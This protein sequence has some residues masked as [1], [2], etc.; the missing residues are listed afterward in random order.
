MSHALAAYEMRR[1]V[2]GSVVLAVGLSL[3]ALVVVA[4]YPSIQE[5]SAELDAYVESLP[6]AFRT[7]LGVETFTTVEGFL[8]AELYQFGWV[9]L[10][11]LYFAYRAAGLVADAV[12]SGRMDT[13]LATPISRTRVVLETFAG[14]LVPLVVVNVVS[15]VAVHAGVVAVG[16]S[17]DVAR[18]AAVH[19]LSVPYLLVCAG[20]GLLLSV[21]LQR[22]DAAE[23][24]ALGAVFGLWLVESVAAASEY[25]WLAAVSPT[26]YYDPTA[27]LLHGEYDP[28]GAALLAVV[29]VALV[30]ASVGWFRRVDVE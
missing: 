14:L 9:L 23:R 24:G 21:S 11:G 22:S 29:A 4:I 6:P 2:K 10:L 17:V 8:A 3:L 13:L 1:R 30:A 15:F 25:D 7:A 16:E 27:V 18:L 19:L 28:G 5:S 20:V 12:E 26:H